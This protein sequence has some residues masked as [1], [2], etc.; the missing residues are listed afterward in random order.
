MS[1]NAELSPIAAGCMSWGIGGIQASDAQMVTLMHAFIAQGINTFDH[2]DI[3]G[4]YTTEGA[5]G[6]AFNQSNIQR[7]TIRLITKCGIRKPDNGAH[8]I[9][10][11]N[12]DADYII[13]C[14]ERSLSLLQTD[15]IDVFLLHRPDPLLQAD[16]VAEAISLLKGQGKIIDF[17]VSNFSP[18]QAE[19]L[20]RLIPIEYNQ[21]AFSATHHW[22]L[23]DGTLDYALIHKIQP[24]AWAPLGTY[25]K[26]DNPLL[27][28]VVQRLSEKLNEPEHVIL[29]SWIMKHPTS[30]IPV[31]GTTNAARIASL[32]RAHSG[33]LTKQEW[34]EIWTASMG[35][36][37]P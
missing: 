27:S 22:P 35:Q 7:D 36:N 8:Y 12:Y 13:R 9:K 4:N 11:Y 37:V 16:E 18:F 20:R 33:L 17:G 31:V 15:Y 2:A 29:L 19:V 5:F 28:E 34:T 3:Y 32:Q 30:P 1:V 24:M 21:I 10:H 23:T 14:C 26:E 6:N 25:F